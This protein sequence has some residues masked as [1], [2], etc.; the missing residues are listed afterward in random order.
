MRWWACLYVA[1]AMC[2]TAISGARAGGPP[3]EYLTGGTELAHWH[4]V[5]PDDAA[6]E[7]D[8]RLSHAG[9][10][11]VLRTDQSLH[12]K[13]LR[14]DVRAVPIGQI[15]RAQVIQAG[16][17]TLSVSCAKYLEQCT[18]IW[19]RM[20]KFH[21]FKYGSK[22][23]SGEC[24]KATLALCRNLARKINELI[25]RNKRAP[26][27]RLRPFALTRARHCCGHG[28]PFLTD[29]TVTSGARNISA[30]ATLA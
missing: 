25:K 17:T 19:T 14:T 20:G 10:L 30:A 16:F 21:W 1:G 15:A 18:T 11:L 12:K 7:E 4:W 2:L 27:Q 26:N 13:L 3:V 28:A 24:G 9:S 29:S 6:I 23:L 22:G 5:D 8:Y